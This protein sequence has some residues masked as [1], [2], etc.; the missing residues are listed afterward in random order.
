MTTPFPCKTND[1]ITSPN[2]ASNGQ[3]AQQAINRID[4]CGG[5]EETQ[6]IGN[7]LAIPYS[8]ITYSE[9]CCLKDAWLDAD[10]CLVFCRC[11]K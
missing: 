5:G 1:V 3:P 4:D 10:K 6:L 2:A 9:L 11:M 7:V 8:K